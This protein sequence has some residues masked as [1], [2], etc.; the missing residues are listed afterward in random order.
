[1]GLRSWCGYDRSGVTIESDE[2]P[3]TRSY[4]TITKGLYSRA[5]VKRCSCV[6]LIPIRSGMGQCDVSVGALGDWMTTIKRRREFLD[7]KELT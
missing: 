6:L 2:L 5:R 4:A 3:L 7:P 1:M